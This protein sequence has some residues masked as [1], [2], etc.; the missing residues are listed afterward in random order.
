G[1]DR[2]STGSPAANVESGERPPP[3]LPRERTDRLGLHGGLD[4]LEDALGQEDLTVRRHADQARGLVHDGTDHRVVP[5][6]VEA[7]DSGRRVAAAAAEADA[8]IESVVRTPGTQRLD[9]VAH[10]YR[11]ADGALLRVRDLHGVVE[12]HDD[13]VARE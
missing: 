4:R 10:R 5:P 3:P 1:L 11:H 2:T 6:F 7:D 13:S 8:E 12:R 9:G